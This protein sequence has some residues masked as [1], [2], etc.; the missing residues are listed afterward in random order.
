MISPLAKAKKGESFS[1]C[2]DLVRVGE[3][4]VKVRANG[5]ENDFPLGDSQEGGNHFRM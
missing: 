1:I 3:V 5:A 4:P 2:N